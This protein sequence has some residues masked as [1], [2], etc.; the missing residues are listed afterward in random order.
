MPIRSIYLHIYHPN[1]DQYPAGCR[2]HSFAGLN[3]QDSDKMGA[4]E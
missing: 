4:E 3:Q 2:K 1:I